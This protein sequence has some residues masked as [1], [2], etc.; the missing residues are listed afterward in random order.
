MKAL[1]T[2]SLNPEQL[3]AATIP[4]GPV[5]VFAGAG[6]GKTR[7]IVYR[8]GF[9]M[10]KMDFNSNNIIAVTFTN[11]AADE[12]KNRV[13]QLVGTERARKLIVSTFHSLCTRILR[14]DIHLLNRKNQF[15]IYDDSDQLG[16]LRNIAREININNQKFDL[17]RILYNISSAKN[18]LQT[19]A[20]YQQDVDD[21]YELATKIMFEKYELMLKRF[22]ALDFDDL[23]VYT[24]RLFNDHPDCLQKYQNLF[25]HIL[26]DEYQDTNELQYLLIKQLGRSHRNVFV[27]GDDDQSIY[28]WRGAQPDNLFK[29]E[30]DFPGTQVIILDQNYRSTNTI[31]KAAN[32]VIAKNQKRNPKNLW[33]E[34]SSGEKIRIF[35]CEDEIKEAECMVDNILQKKILKKLQSSNFAIFY[36]TNYQS[37]IIE[38]TLRMRRLPY[39]LLGGI[40]FYDRKEV[41]DIHAYLKFFVNQDDN[42]N[43]LRIINYPRRG[44][45]DQTVETLDSFAL[46]KNISIY[47][48][49][50]SCDGIP[51]LQKATQEKIKQFVELI[52][53]YRKKILKPGLANTLRN[54][55]DEIGLRDE[56]QKECKSPTEFQHRWDNSEEAIHAVEHFELMEGKGIKEY[57]DRIALF[58]DID[59][60]RLSKLERDDTVKLITLHGAKGLEFPHVYIVGLE[61]DILPHLRSSENDNTMQEERRLFYVGITRAQETLTISFAKTRRK[62]GKIYYRTPS[63]FLNEIPDELVL[64]NAE[65]E[66]VSEDDEKMIA[67]E[68]LTRI[69][70]LLN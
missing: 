17:K 22:N 54:F 25:Q 67:K 59:N 62:Y 42:N 26:V 32:A 33:S 47:E 10:S 23:L 51:A 45:G 27:V 14:K 3:K 43:L 29:F 34:K 50:V 15:I 16:L 58:S 30:K 28:G 36:R 69:K 38:E 40:Q 53:K 35:E 64:K 39:S 44:L 31:L 9:L 21:G 12:M 1:N 2:H 8:I 18:R 37:R 41:K 65:Q 5:L 57:L 24:I 13:A 70:E 60:D 4:C 61:E 66:E 56:L 52:E 68:Y 63:R 20:E 55:M 46:S 11:K 7:V 48:A 19:P 6:S 49:M